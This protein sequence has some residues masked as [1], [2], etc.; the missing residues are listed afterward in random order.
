MRKIVNL[1]PPKKRGAKATYFKHSALAKVL[2]GPA[3]WAV[4][5]EC[6]VR[7]RGATVHEIA[8]FSGV[9]FELAEFIL[10]D[11]H[12]ARLGQLSDSIYRPFDDT[13][14]NKTIDGISCAEFAGRL[15]RALNGLCGDVSD[16]SG[17]ADP[18]ET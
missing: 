12:R 13:I 7:S 1:N 8:F 10:I 6:G 17:A 11:F 3:H 4:A 9:R 16:K 2:F 18:M 5:V 14:L 15:H